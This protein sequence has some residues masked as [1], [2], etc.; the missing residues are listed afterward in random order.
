M[1][2]NRRGGRDRSNYYKGNEH[3]DRVP[4]HNNDGGRRVSFK[5]HNSG[6]NKHNNRQ[7]GWDNKVRAALMDEDIEMSGNMRGNDRFNNRRRNNH[8]EGGGWSRNPKVFQESPTQ[9]YKISVRNGHKYDKEYLLKLLAGFIKPCPMIPYLFKISRDET[10]FIVEDHRAAQELAHADR[11]I[12]ANDGWKLFIRVRPVTPL[13]EVD[14][15]LSTAIKGVMSTRYNTEL[16][17]LNL[18]KFHSDGLFVNQE[19]FCPLNRPNIMMAVLDIIGE[20]IPDL[21]A[22]DLSE[23]KL[24]VTEHMKLM[25]EKCPNV[26]ML[27]LGNNKLRDVKQLDSLKGL[28]LEEI[29]LDGNSLCDRFTEKETYIR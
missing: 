2:N 14:T 5:N 18:S 11:K 16:K 17:A 9:W 23:N 26:K 15:K 4:S 1:P 10:S 19:I 29:I 8:E 7:R 22:L 24:N 3:D 20:I 25:V 13:V 28:P 27:H 21:I 6:R 12:T